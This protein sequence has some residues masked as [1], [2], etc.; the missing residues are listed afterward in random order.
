MK[1]IIIGSVSEDAGKTSIIVGLARA[2]N[3][4]FAYLKPFGDRLIYRKKRLWDYDGA[5]ITNI[6][7]LEQSSEDMTIGFEHSKLRYMYDEASTKAKL[8]DMANKLSGNNQ[9]LI[10][11]GGKD[12]THGAS[13]RLDTLSLTRYFDGKLILV[14]SGD[15]GTIIDD[16]TFIK[17]YVDTSNIDLSIIINKVSNLEDYKNNHLRDIKE[18]GVNV[19]GVLPCEPVL[20]QFSMSYLAEKL[21]ARIIAGEKG[22]NQKVKNILVG[23]MSGDAAVRYPLFKTEN[24][25]AITSGDRVDYIVAALESSTAG[26]ILTNNVIPPQNIISKASDKNVPMLLVPFDTFATAKQVDDLVSLLTKDD[27]E[28]IDLIQKL[29]EQNVDINSII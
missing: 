21:Q 9:F 1:N 27:T 6:F 18:L 23:S 19:L 20:T 3:K 5:L 28:R 29:V 12:L 4:K 10:I 26:I 7:G 13:I 8:L 24:K 25:L 22:L 16:V 15:E 14:I 11:E 17:K 2:V